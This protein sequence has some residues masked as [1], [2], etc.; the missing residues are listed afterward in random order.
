MTAPMP[1]LPVSAVRVMKTNPVSRP[2]IVGVI[3]SY[4]ALLAGVL[5]IFAVPIYVSLTLMVVGAGIGLVSDHTKIPMSRIAWIVLIGG[6]VL[7]LCIVGLYGHDRILHWRPHPAGYIP[8]WAI[9]F[10]GVRHVRHLILF[11]GG[12]LEAAC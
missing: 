8:A 12:G 4:I 1:E 7:I 9:L 6:W 2:R 5:S 10:H 11:S 3:I